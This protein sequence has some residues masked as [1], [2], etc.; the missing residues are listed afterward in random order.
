MDKIT[1]MEAL[2]EA[3]PDLVSQVEAAAKASEKAD[4]IQAERARIQGIEA[5]EAAIGDKE[6]V[7]AA[8]YGDTP[9]TAEQLVFKVMQAQA[10]IGATVVKNLEDDAANSGAAGVAADPT[11]GDPKAKAEDE[12]AQAVS[13]IAGFRPKNKKEG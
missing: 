10:A 4:G 11:G 5:I 13:M 1:T 12:E 2:R 8:K 9:L 6:L 7:K 3:Y